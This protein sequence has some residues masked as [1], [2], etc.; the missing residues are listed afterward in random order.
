VAWGASPFSVLFDDGYWPLHN[1]ARVA[2]QRSALELIPKRASVS[3]TYSY[4][5]HLTHRTHI[6]D[7]PEPWQRVNWG[8]NGEN[9]PDPGSVQWIALDRRLMSNYDVRLVDALLKGQFTVRFD[10]QDVVI[11][12]RTAPGGQVSLP[13][14]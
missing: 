14:G 2:I 6:Y 8:V 11:A 10:R 7:F 13:A 1:D 9:F 12:Q 4:V 5:P 3:A